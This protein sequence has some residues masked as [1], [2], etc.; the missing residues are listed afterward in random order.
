M[1]VVEE[2][3]KSP[4]P[5]EPKLGGPRIFERPPLLFLRRRRD[6]GVPLLVLN[7]TRHNRDNE[8][9]S[10]GFLDEMED[11]KLVYELGKLIMMVVEAVGTVLYSQGH[12]ESQP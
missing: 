2:L 9:S 12:G 1:E 10:W 3:K 5:P 4:L 11:L 6:A 7:I 8:T